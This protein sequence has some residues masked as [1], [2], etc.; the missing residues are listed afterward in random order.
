M[1]KIFKEAS[2][3]GI[4]EPGHLYIFD[5]CSN[6]GFSPEPIEYLFSISEDKEILQALDMEFCIVLAEDYEV[7]DFLGVRKINRNCHE[8]KVLCYEKKEQREV[9][10]RLYLHRIQSFREC[11]SKTKRLFRRPK[12]D[13]L[14]EENR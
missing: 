6:R 2:V 1:N 9:R 3:A 13:S 14:C 8:F 5:D 4:I 10:L 11:L 12:V 7:R